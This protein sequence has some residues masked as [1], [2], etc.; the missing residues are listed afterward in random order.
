MNSNKK[1][2]YYGLKAK[3]KSFLGKVLIGIG[4]LISIITEI[5]TNNSLLAFIVFL[6]I[7]GTGIYLIITAKA[8]RFDY[9]RQSGTII[10]KGDF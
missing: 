1:L 4:L 10:H 5:S 9:Q 8:Q 3:I 7:A 6:L 2:F